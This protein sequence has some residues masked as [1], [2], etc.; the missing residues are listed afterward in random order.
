MGDRRPAPPTLRLI[1]RNVTWICD[2]HA[3]RP[4]CEYICGED[5]RRLADFVGRYENLAAD[6]AAAC[7][8]AGIET[9]LPRMNASRHENYAGYY[10][11]WCRDFVATRYGRD[12]AEFGYTFGEG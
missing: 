4:Q 11:S 8:R 6:F 10:D 3:A 9:V 1:D 7:R 12:I 5:G 2:M